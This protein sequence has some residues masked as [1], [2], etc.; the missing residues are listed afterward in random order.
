L[1]RLCVNSLAI[2][3][4][5]IFF[6]AADVRKNL[7]Q[8]TP[9]VILPTGKIRA[10]PAAMDEFAFYRA[11]PDVADAAARIKGFGSAAI[12]F[13]F[14]LRNAAHASDENIGGIP[15]S[16]LPH[17]AGI[18]VDPAISDVDVFHEAP[19]SISDLWKSGAIFLPFAFGLLSYSMIL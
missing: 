13:D 2:D 16:E 8:R 7:H 4:F 15:Q 18:T 3:G 5:K 14:R 9:L 11:M 6:G 10:Y 17:R 12:A 19:F 1:R